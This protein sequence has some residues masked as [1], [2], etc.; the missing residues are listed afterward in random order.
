MVFLILT[1][2]S[3]KFSCEEANHFTKLFF[4]LFKYRRINVKEVYYYSI[5]F[6]LKLS[7]FSSFKDTYLLSIRYMCYM[8]HTKSKNYNSE[9]FD[10]LCE[11]ILRIFIQ[12]PIFFALRLAHTQLDFVLPD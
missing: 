10:P 9:N 12:D 11:N 6:K 2:L 8:N 4:R 5:Y 7:L 3:L 1:D